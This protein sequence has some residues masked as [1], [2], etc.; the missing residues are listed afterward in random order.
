MKSD[1]CSEKEEKKK[2][3][4]RDDSLCQHLLSGYVTIISHRQFMS[5]LLR[6]DLQRK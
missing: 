6:P 5:A 3:T 2:E 4:V 1:V